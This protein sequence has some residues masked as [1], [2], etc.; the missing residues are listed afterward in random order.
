[1][2]TLHANEKKQHEAEKALQQQQQQQ[3]SSST[4]TPPTSTPQQQSTPQQTPFLLVNS[5]APD[6]PAQEAGL[7]H[8]DLVL[9]FGSINA[10]QYALRGDKAM[11]QQV[12]Q[13]LNKPLKV[14]VKRF[15]EIIELE[16]VNTKW[17][18]RR[19]FGCHL[20]KP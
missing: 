6:S 15:N 9:Q 17:S 7:Q 11:I 12:E 16:L 13:S 2:F 5:V 10:P 8:G 4:T 18:G 3:S 14:Q 19:Y 20:I 1:M